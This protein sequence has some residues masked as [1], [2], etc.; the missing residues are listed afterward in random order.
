[1]GLDSLLG[2][3]LVLALENRFGVRIPVMS[4]SES[5]TI[6]RLS[7]KLIELLQGAQTESSLSSEIQLLAAQHNIDV[8]Q[9]TIDQTAEQLEA[10]LQ[11]PSSRNLH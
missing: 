3:E 4:L 7:L 11:Q 6:E 5:P 9:E 8:S 2:V 1:M 10:E